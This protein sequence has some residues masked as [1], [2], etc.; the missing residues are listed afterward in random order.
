MRYKI[1][2]AVMAE[3]EEFRKCVEKCP[4]KEKLIIVNNWNNSKVKDQ[5]DVLSKQ[6]A[7]IHSH[8]ENIGC[9]PAMNI[10]LRAIGRDNLDYVIILSPAALFTNSVQDFVDIIE[11]REK[12]EKNYYYLTIGSYQTDLHAF[13]VTK[14]CVDE[15][16]LYDENFYPVYF[17]DTD[18]GY[19]MSLIGAS[20]TIVRPQRICQGLGM[21]VSKDPRIFQHYW[22]NAPHIKDYYFRKW[23]GDHT[24]ETFK[25][26]FNDP[27][28]SI[29][30]WEREES[31]MIKLDQ[32]PL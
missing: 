4:D 32:I 5:C 8:P 16:G 24:Q 20:K 19:R 12:T 13:A 30:D 7:E 11:E 27:N 14:R 31:L 1:L 17:D 22:A 6:G 23:G 26:P 10:G 29:K 25:T 2:I 3:V 21:G 18:Y 15:V 9:G 28:K